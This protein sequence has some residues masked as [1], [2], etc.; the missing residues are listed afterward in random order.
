LAFRA[1]QRN[2]QVRVLAAF[3]SLR[4]D[5]NVSDALEFA[6]LRFVRHLGAGAWHAGARRDP[7]HS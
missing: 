1:T 5:S 6:N 2:S 7:R 3:T 4:H